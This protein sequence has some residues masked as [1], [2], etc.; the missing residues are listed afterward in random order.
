MITE[1][2]IKKFAGKHHLDYVGPTGDGVQGFE[3][4]RFFSDE[5]IILDLEKEVPVGLIE[6]YMAEATDG[7]VGDFKSW[8][9]KYYER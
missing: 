5:D 6:L 1:Q 7:H 4:G 9:N 8:L 2:Q 3:G